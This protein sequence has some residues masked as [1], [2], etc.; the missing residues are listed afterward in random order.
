MNEE[1]LPGDF[2]ISR[3]RPRQPTKKL[4]GL[5]LCVYDPFTCCVMWS[6]CEHSQFS[7]HVLH[8]SLIKL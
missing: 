7:K 1:I 3:V 8:E 5:V 4:I 6:N 2:V